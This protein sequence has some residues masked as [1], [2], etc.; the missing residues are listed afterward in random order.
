[1]AIDS[2]GRFIDE[3]HFYTIQGNGSP[4]DRNISQMQYST[5][6]NSLNPYIWMDHTYAGS[7]GYRDGSYLI[8][9]SRESSFFDR[10]RLAH[11]KNYLKPIVRAMIDPVFTEYADRTVVD[12]AG[13]PITDCMFT[14]FLDD[15]DSADTF[16]Q[17][18]TKQAVTLARL[19]GVS[20]TVMDN[21]PS[22]AQPATVSQALQDRIFPYVY[23]KRAY[24]VE[25]YECDQFGNLIEITFAEEP[26]K[27]GNELQKR[28]RRWTTT[29]SVVLT[30]AKNNAKEWITVSSATH[31]LGVVPV[32]MTFS[33]QRE[34]NSKILVDP[35]LYDIA[36]LN[37]V[38][39]NQSAEIRDQERAQAFSIFYCQGVPSQDLVISNNTYINIP[40]EATISPG[41][42]SPD[43]GIIA[44][45]VANQEQMRKD[46][47]AIAEQSGVVGVQSQTSGVAMAYDFYA[48]ESTLKQTASM[49]TTLEQKI[50][51][52][53]GRYTAETF[54][55]TVSYPSDFAPMGQD[56][57]VARLDK[58]LRIPGLNATFANKV[59]QKLARMILN[60][61]DDDV[62]NE[63]TAAI[64]A[65]AKPVPEPAGDVEADLSQVETTKPDTIATVTETNT[66]V[67]NA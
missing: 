19:H 30:K 18:Y 9:F 13:N 15:C 39:F 21:F 49:A 27:I 12:D 14:D 46:L 43:F 2:Q 44:G 6:I 57:E 7:H 23:A 52:L 47:F 45:L 58:V 53:F 50:A 11:F 36:K 34:C 67:A 25:D 33:E 55:Y 26:V 48:H 22:T 60:D 62:I 10:R 32:I 65:G 5:N 3:D 16:I 59:Q 37:F 40:S 61:E 8:P 42:A 41:Y 51:T 38:I 17:D 54:V 35:P 31:N 56:N 63:V 28:W 29:E 1:M 4:Q 64:E 24:E 20:F 66:V